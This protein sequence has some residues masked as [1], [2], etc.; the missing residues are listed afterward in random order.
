MAKYLIDSTDIEIEEVSGTENLKFNFASGNSVEQMIGDLSN[1]ST[2]SK[3]NVVNAINEVNNSTIYST[4]EKVVGKWINNKPLYRK[5][6]STGNLPNA[7]VK[8]IN[9]GVSNLDKYINMYGIVSDG[10]YSVPLPYFYPSEMISTYGI[11]IE[12]P[13]N[14]SINIITGI[15][16]T[17]Y[18][19]YIVLEYT[20]TTD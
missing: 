18:S 3:S 16:R 4:T 20:K 5:V 7:S 19:G 9:H 6:I 10:A 1:L 8:N 13:N 17:G 12:A 2:T 11:G 15:D 14:L